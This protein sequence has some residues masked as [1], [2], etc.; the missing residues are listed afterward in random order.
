MPWRTRGMLCCAQ[1][2]W[3]DLCECVARDRRLVPS[4]GVVLAAGTSGPG[5]L[6][7]PMALVAAVSGDRHHI[8]RH[9]RLASNHSVPARTAIRIPRQFHGPPFIAGSIPNSGGYDA[10]MP[11][12]RQTAIATG[13]PKVTLR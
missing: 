5:S 12:Q 8:R 3:R 1:E 7:L 11:V 13:E 10:H 6:A 9:I 2:T 4:V